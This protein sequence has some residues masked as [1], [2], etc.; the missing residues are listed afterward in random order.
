MPDFWM[1]K[2]MRDRPFVSPVI[3][4]EMILRPISFEKKKRQRVGLMG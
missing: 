3:T 2:K 1:D 4:P